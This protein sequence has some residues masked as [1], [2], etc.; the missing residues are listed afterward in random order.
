MFS[1]RNS[2]PFEFRM[3]VS[4]Y[5]GTVYSMHIMHKPTSAARET[6]W[7]VF[8]RC[9]PTVIGT[10][11]GLSAV[12]IWGTILVRVRECS[13]LVYKHTNVSTRTDFLIQVELCGPATTDSS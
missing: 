12:A 10:T 11:I 1:L 6:V 7:T 4:S 5:A 9:K 3:L 2:A 13:A 8:Q